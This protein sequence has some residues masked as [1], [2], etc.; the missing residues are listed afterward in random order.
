M[1][2]NENGP[3]TTGEK[4]LFYDQYADFSNKV[5]EEIRR[6]AFGEDIGQ[7]GWLTAGEYRD[8]FRW[9]D[10][11]PGQRVL[12]AASGSGGPAL[13]LARTTGCRVTG[14]DINEAGIATATE[15]AKAQD[16]DEMVDFRHVDLSR[17]LPFDDETFD[18]I[19]CIDA[20]NHIYNRSELFA[21]W[22]RL[23][24]PGGQILYTDP[25]VVGGMIS[26]EEMMARSGSMGLF[27]FT[28]L[29]INEGLIV[30]AGFA[31]PTVGDLTANIAR[32][33]GNWHKSRAAHEADL[34]KLEGDEAY[35]DFQHFLSA[36]H[37]L[38]AER[39]LLR[40]VYIARKPGG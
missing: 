36:V 33:S 8:F 34:R 24:R 28:P 23:L 12:E 27:I 35:E 39:R 2:D 3:S 32:V 29:H 1:Q 6:E 14:V 30:G 7:F 40:M 18:A 5:R 31:P 25:I 20:I 17:P 16:L 21:V 22:H 13:F 38:S 9:L 4:T 11:R 15:A 10:L 37:T 19:V 26:R